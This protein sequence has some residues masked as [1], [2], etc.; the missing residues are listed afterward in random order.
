MSEKEQIDRFS[1][2]LVALINR[3]RAEY[4]LTL[5]SAVGVLEVVKHELIHEQITEE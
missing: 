5:A 4:E 1:K 2:E 3:Y